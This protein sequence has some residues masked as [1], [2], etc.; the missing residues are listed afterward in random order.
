MHAEPPRHVWSRGNIVWF[1]LFLGALALVASHAIGFS[2]TVDDLHYLEAAERWADDPPFVGT[3]HWGL[4][5]VVTLPLALAMRLFGQGDLAYHV[6]PWAYQLG[7]FLA[8]FVYLYRRLGVFPA[9]VACLLYLSVPVVRDYS[10]RNY[11]DFM[12]MVWVSVALAL[13]YEASQAGEVRRQCLPALFSGVAAAIAI[14]TRETAAWI[15]LV[16]A[17]LILTGR[18]IARLAMLFA[19]FGALIPLGAD[20]LY[21]HHMTGDWLYRLHVSSQHTG[22]LSTH[23]RGGVYH[24]RP[25]LNPDLASRWTVDGPV[26]VHWAINPILYFFLD[27][28]YGLLGWIALAA[29]LLGIGGRHLPPN[30]RAIVG[31][32][33]LVAMLAFVFPTYVLMVSQRPRYYLFSLLCLTIVTAILIDTHWRRALFRRVL[34]VLM[35]LQALAALASLQLLTPRMVATREAGGW[36]ASLPGQTHVTQEM[37]AMERFVMTPGDHAAKVRTGVPPIGGRFLVITKDGKPLQTEEGA[38]ALPA[39]ICLRRVGTRPIPPMGIVALVAR[40]GGQLGFDTTRLARR[41]YALDLFVRQADGPCPVLA[42]PAPA[43]NQ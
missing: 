43:I 2:F 29:A 37:G 34:A 3:T 25:F 28:R 8:A 10:G 30:R 39:N 6:V 36:I 31:L 32:L 21:L 38:A 20:L 16:Y 24:G 42:Q 40:V 13:L 17:V 4:R 15:V 1:L 33:L 41:R 35:L 7:F 14:L 12:E 19:L 18:P 27:P 9:L 26:Y 22:I 11:P 23:M 5:H